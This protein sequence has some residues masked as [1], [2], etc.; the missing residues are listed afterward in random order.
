MKIRTPAVDEISWI[1]RKGWLYYDK[2]LKERMGFTCGIVGLPNVGKSTLF[3]AITAAGADV[4]NYPFCTIDPNVGVVAVPDKRIDRLVDIYQPPKI[5]PTTLEFLDIAGLVK[6]ASQGEG[7]GNQFLSH[8]RSVDAIAHVVRCFD[9]EN[10]I[11]VNG[12]IDPKNDIE[13]IETE[14]ILKDL[15]TLEKKIT[16][17]DK[18]SRTGDKKIKSEQEL[19]QSLKTHL[20]SGRLARYYELHGEDERFWMRDMH[21]L[22]N[23][24][25][26]Y[27]CNVHEAELKTGNAYVESVRTAAAKEDARVVVVSAAVEAEIAELPASERSDFLASLG[28]Q[29]SGLSQVVREGYDLLKLLTFFTAGPKEVHAWTVRKGSTAPQ[30]AGEIHSDFEQGFIRAEI[31]KYADLDR[32]GSELAV[33]EAGLLHIEGREYCIEDGDLLVVRFNV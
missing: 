27:V 12:K 33:K 15:E 7:L 30:A 21:L 3:N 24:P 2:I 23:K 19:Y 29:E 31:I 16:D 32:L 26:M 1:A 10:I 8:I 17:A 4:A 14:L 6:G 9:D 18:R 11:H 22:T 20:S 28:L 13:V 5:V 25:V